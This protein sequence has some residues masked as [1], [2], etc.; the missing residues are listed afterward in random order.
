[1]NTKKI[2]T[3]WALWL[4]ML[5]TVALWFT[6]FGSETESALR[7]INNE[8][9][10]LEVQMIDNSNWYDNKQGEINIL[11]IERDEFKTAN[12]E[13]NKQKKALQLEKKSLGLN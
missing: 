4:F 3:T 10:T 12:I 13:L 6:M 1:M 11:A 7:S 8:I 9:T 2:I 5:G